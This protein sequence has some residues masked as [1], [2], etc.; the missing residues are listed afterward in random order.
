MYALMIGDGVLLESS[1]SDCLTAMEAIKTY[2]YI[3][4][5]TT[6]PTLRVVRVGGRLDVRIGAAWLN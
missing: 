5:I 3:S 6:D 4:G 1:E 2:N